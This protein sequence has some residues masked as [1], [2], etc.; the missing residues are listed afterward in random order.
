MDG[1]GSVHGQA[2]DDAGPVTPTR[3]PTEIRTTFTI[4]TPTVR[5][6]HIESLTHTVSTFEDDV[7]DDMRN[8]SQ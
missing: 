1:T 5:G 3:Q 4:T 8:Y 7:L 6:P 2:T